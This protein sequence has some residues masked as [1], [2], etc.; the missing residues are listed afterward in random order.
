MARLANGIETME[1]GVTAWRSIINDNFARIYTKSEI[2]AKLSGDD[3][4]NFRA[5]NI[6]ASGDL[7]LGGTLEFNDG[8]EPS[9]LGE[10]LG[11]IK[12]KVAGQIVKIPYFKA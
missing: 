3:A 4:T 12:V 2:D 7:K 11:F 6:S 8:L 10:P 9:N 5:K 1:L